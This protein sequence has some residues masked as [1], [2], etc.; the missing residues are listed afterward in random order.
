VQPNRS[1]E[2]TRSGDAFSRSGVAP[3]AYAGRLSSNVR[4]H[5]TRVTPM[6]LALLVAGI[7]LLASASAATASAAVSALA[8]GLLGVCDPKFGCSF[9]LQFAAGVSAVVGLLLGVLLLCVLAGY[10]AATSRPV[11]AKA[12]L[13]TAA[14][15]GAALGGLWS[16]VAARSYM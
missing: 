14:G 3:P 1:L 16:V 12:S 5:K 11:A 8:N 2:P 6:H 4:P 10:T 7:P 15:V 9:G 13:V